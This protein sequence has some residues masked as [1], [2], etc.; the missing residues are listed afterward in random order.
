MIHIKEHIVHVIDDSSSYWRVA[1][2]LNY[3]VIDRKYVFIPRK[4]DKPL[5]ADDLIELENQ[6]SQ[7]NR[8]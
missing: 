1:G 2:R 6:I 8:K 3:N 5:L 7:L 4:P